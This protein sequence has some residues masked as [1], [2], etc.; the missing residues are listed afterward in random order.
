MG[1]Q[2]LYRLSK[3]HSGI[4]C[5]ACHGSTHAEWPVLPESGTFVAND[6]MAAIQLQGHTG[7]I[8]ECTACHAAGSLPV[9]LG[10]PHGMHPVGDSRFI[11]S[12][13]K[14]SLGESRP[15]PGLPRSERSGHGS[16]Q[17]AG[18]PDRG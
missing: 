1:I 14:H 5:E 3:G 11:S 15:M 13:R 10:G 17:G 2:V 16:V 6:N 4:F 7:K 8:M 9:A 18:R 12:H